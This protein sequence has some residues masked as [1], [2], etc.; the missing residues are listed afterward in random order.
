ML[1]RL[2]GSVFALGATVRAAGNRF[3]EI[4][5]TVHYSYWS[6]GSFASSTGNQ[7]THCIFTEGTNTFSQGN[8]VMN[9]TLCRE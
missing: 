3:T 6:I 7:A 4:R 9:P 2:W 1:V 8:Q 5:D